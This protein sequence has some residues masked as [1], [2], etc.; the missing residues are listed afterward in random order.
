MSEVV[1][2][3]PLAAGATLLLLLSAGACVHTF[4][5]RTLGAKTTLG[6]RASQ[7]PQGESFRVSKTAVYVFWGFGSASRPVLDRV[8]AGQVSGESEI[9]NLRV[10]VK[11]RFSDVLVTVLTA[12]VIV[13]RTITYEGVVVPDSAATTA[14]ASA[15]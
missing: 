15:N 11:S 10:T 7:Q 14:G 4:D 9:R 13:P 6:D 1:I 2:R 3:R 5:A 12:G 8:L